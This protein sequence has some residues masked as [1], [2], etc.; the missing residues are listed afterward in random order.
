MAFVAQRASA[1]VRWTCSLQRSELHMHFTAPHRVHNSSPD[2]SLTTAL[3]TIPGL[4]LTLSCHGCDGNGVCTRPA[5]SIHMRR[6]LQD[7]VHGLWIHTVDDGS[8]DR[9]CVSFIGSGG[10]AALSFLHP[11]RVGA[12]G[13]LCF[14]AGE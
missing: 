8:T 1:D 6:L 14:E 10:S 11:K 13:V 9:L 7:A 3:R 4:L 12:F 5:R 2:W